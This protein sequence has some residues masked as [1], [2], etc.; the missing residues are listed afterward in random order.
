MIAQ[1]NVTLVQESRR[2]GGGVGV[3]Y[4]RPVNTRK[5]IEPTSAYSELESST[6]NSLLLL[7]AVPTNL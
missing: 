3:F 2:G 4:R 1:Q 5:N 7:H 6:Q